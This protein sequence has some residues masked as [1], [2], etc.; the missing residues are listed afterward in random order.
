MPHESTRVPDDESRA[1][2]GGLLESSLP[3]VE[4]LP[5]SDSGVVAV[6]TVVSSLMRME[7][8]SDGAIAN[9]TEGV[10]DGV[11]DE[12]EEGVGA[13]GMT[14]GEAEGS[15]LVVV[16]VVLLEMLLSTLLLP[17]DCS[18]WVKICMAFSRTTS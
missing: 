12:V 17:R 18:S 4:A 5:S 9:V 2:V 8:G 11:D 10:A 13:E 1:S 6:G 16:E 7:E 14:E 15:P 3:A